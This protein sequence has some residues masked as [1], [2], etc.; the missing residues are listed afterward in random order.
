[1]DETSDLL[2]ASDT[3]RR[4]TTRLALE[5]QL[6]LSEGARRRG[7]VDGSATGTEVGK[8]AA[9][10]SKPVSVSRGTLWVTVHSASGLPDQ[11]TVKPS[12]YVVVTVGHG[13]HLEKE[14]VRLPGEK[15][16][17]RTTQSDRARGAS[18]AWLQYRTWRISPLIRCGRRRNGTTCP[19]RKILKAGS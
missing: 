3:E 8:K 1:M 7:L 11:H 12:T 14:H 4:A 2:D 15:W 5:Q 13:G 16:E 6:A 17:R 9:E 10:T 19:S 18:P